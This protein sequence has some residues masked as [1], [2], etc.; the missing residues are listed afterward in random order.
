MTQPRPARWHAPA[1]AAVTVLALAP[2]LGR[3]FNIDETLFLWAGRHIQA[4]PGDFYGFPVNWYGFV[5][6][7]HEVTKN[8][9]LACFYIAWAG[10]LLGWSEVALHTAFLLPAIAAVLGAY[11]LARRWCAH[12]FEA[13]LLGAATPVFLASSATVMCDTLMLALYCWAAWTWM[14]GVERERRGLLVLSGFLIAACGLTKYFG[15]S[16]VP[17]L[18]LWSW[19][20]TRSFGA[21]IGA[22]A[23]PVAIFGLYQY[24]TWS[25]Y[26]RGLLFD[27]ASYAVGSGNLRSISTTARSL[28]GL[29]FAGGCLGGVLFFAPFLASRRAL[30]LGGMATLGVAALVAFAPRAVDVLEPPSILAVT[31]LLELQLVLAALGGVCVL[32]LAAGELRRSRS[33]DSILLCLWLVGTWTFATFVNWTNNG[34]SILPM[35]PAAGILLVRQLEA[36][37]PE[38]RRALRVALRSAFVPGALLALAVTWADAQWSNQ[39]R[40]SAGQLAAKHARPGATLWYEGH[41]GFQYYMERAGARALDLSRDIVPQ[42]ERL[43]VPINNTNVNVIDAKY[44]GT[45]DTL[46]PPPQRW[47]HT[48]DA[49]VGA[50]F[51]S[52]LFGPLPFA[53]GPPLQEAYL[54]YEARQALQFGYPVAPGQPPLGQQQ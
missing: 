51:Y 15:V 16:L 47:L 50:G 6:P 54:V 38:P 25:M 20:R 11:A 43:I 8:P 31:P 7:M 30:L 42:G 40:E 44:V 26:G 52:S 12:P 1:L 53:F 49:R 22:M 21:W 33:P 3:A 4:H 14:E 28:I 36:R 29:L 18:A 37:F 27:A 41:W 39:I 32:G 19:S 45:V 23:I 48:L 5:Q 24:A 10:G 46:R 13:A 2:F 34:R 17:L 9:P 35:A